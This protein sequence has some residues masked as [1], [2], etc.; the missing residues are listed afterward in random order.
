MP[1]IKKAKEAIKS[2]K[3]PEWES[4]TA[5]CPFDREDFWDLWIRLLKMPK[6]EKKPLSAIELACK[7]LKRF[8]IDFAASLVENAIIGNYQ[9]VVF[10]DTENKYNYWLQQNERNNGTGNKNLREQV[11]RE[12]AERNYDNRTI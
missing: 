6:W 8:H 12:F 7:K 10:A 9:G 1:T 11:N 4:E 2:K 3:S 5:P